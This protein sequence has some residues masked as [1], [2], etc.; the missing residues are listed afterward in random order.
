MFTSIVVEGAFL[1]VT[2]LLGLMGLLNLLRHEHS[3]DLEPVLV[4]LGIL[5]LLH[6]LSC[7]F[8]WSVGIPEGSRVYEAAAVFWHVWVQAQL[9]CKLIGC[10]DFFILGFRYK[11]FGNELILLLSGLIFSYVASALPGLLLSYLGLPY[12]LLK[13]FV[14]WVVLLLLLSG[15]ILILHNSLSKLNLFG[16]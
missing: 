15:L 2:L 9:V 10:C 11:W 14:S 6:W 1:N 13:L 7:N 8:T 4:L 12:H 5:H 16:Q 3:L